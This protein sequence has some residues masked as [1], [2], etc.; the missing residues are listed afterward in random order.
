MHPINGI[1]VMGHKV[2]D[3]GMRHGPMGLPHTVGHPASA[4][5]HNALTPLGGRYRMPRA[6]RPL[7]QKAAPVTAVTSVTSRRSA[8][9]GTRIGAVRAIRRFLPTGGASVNALG[10]AFPLSFPLFPL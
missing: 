1:L 2:H 6:E 8:P 5:P 7:P 9:L 4:T 3:V 10:S